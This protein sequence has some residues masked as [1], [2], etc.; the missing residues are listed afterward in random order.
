MKVCLKMRN[1]ASPS[2]NREGEDAFGP[3]RVDQLLELH[4]KQEHASPHLKRLTI[5]LI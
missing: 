3:I 5:I 2:T 1:Y 4:K